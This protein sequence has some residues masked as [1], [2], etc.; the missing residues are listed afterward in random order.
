MC[1]GTIYY[2][3]SDRQGLSGVAFVATPAISK[4]VLGYNPIS[5]RI[6]SIRLQAKPLNLSVVQVYAPTSAAS[7]DDI[8]NFYNA[9]QDV[10]DGLPNKD[11]VL[12]VG[13]FN[14]KIG[15]G[16]QHDDEA[17]ILGQFGLGTRNERGDLLSEFCIG[18]NLII[19]NTMFSQHPRRLYTWQGPVKS[20]RNQIDYILIK[21]RWKSSIKVAKTLPGADIGSD[22]QLLIADVRVKLKKTNNTQTVKRFNLQNISKHYWLE[23]N[24]R[25]EEL[26]SYEEE[27][28]PE[29]LWTDIKES[30]LDS[31]NKHVPVKRR[32]KATPWLSR[33]VIDLADERRQL[34]EA[35]L[36]TSNMYRMMSKEIQQKSRRDK[37]THLNH[38]CNELEDHSAKNNSRYLFRGVKDLTRKTKAK[39]ATIKDE[40]GKVLTEENEIKDRWK[41]YCEKLYAS[42]EETSVDQADFSYDDE[43]EPDIL[44]S[45][46]KNAIRKL[47]NN[48]A[49]GI[50][51]I[52]G[53]LLKNFDN[54]GVKILLQ[55]C[56]KVWH[57]RIWP[58]DWKKSLFI[59]LPKKGDI[60]E[61]KN[62]RTIALIP[63]ASKILLH[64]LN[65]RLR[66]H[67]ER[68][69]PPEQAGF[70][71]GR[72]TRDH[73]ANIRHIIEKCKEYR[74][75]VYLCFI[76]YSKAFD[77]VRYGPLW[78]AL[79]ALGIPRHLIHLMKNLYDGQLA[80]VR[81]AFGNSEWFSL[82]QGVRQG[83]ILSPTLFNMYAEYIMRKV[84]DGWHGGISIGGWQLNNLR[85]ADDT[86]LLATSLQELSVLVSRVKRESEM[87]GLHLNVTKTKLMIIGEEDGDN[88]QL[89]VDG[90]EIE[91]VKQ[92]NFLGSLIT[93][94]GGCDKE[95]RRR[96]AMAR[97]AMTQL[98]KIWANRGI[99]KTTKVRLVQALIFPI[100]TYACET[101]TLTSAS[102]K[103]INAF[104]MWCWRR[105]L[106]ITWIMKRTNNSVLQEVNVKNR[107]LGIINSHT[108]SYFGH[109][110]RRQDVCLEKSLMQG[111]I[112]GGRRPGRPKARWIDRIKSTAGQ[113]LRR[114]YQLA[115]D[116]PLWRAIVKVTSHQP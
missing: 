41:R 24:N 30:I 112:E 25:F 47:K 52:P 114:I 115:A 64:I 17:Q 21:K 50:D 49:P 110:A 58:D 15:K 108:L 71:R 85:Y 62:N 94:E 91:K 113:P 27:R 77:C 57:T 32:K 23:T 111:K 14:A 106:R 20:I 28:T 88:D 99:T 3:G 43:E 29:E 1:L 100:A 65:E 35:G 102:C 54:A 8:N 53:E 79:E 39:L 48:K 4:F 86:T 19:S 73:I 87:M 107:L 13:D 67:I 98:S 51:D 101:W 7:E 34:K 74:R 105:M 109:V 76:D 31:A 38:L 95:I 45:E 68:E 97:S 83:C 46:V 59:T 72:G 44:L 61:C 63:H 33:E 12:V 11:V 42:Q 16:T 84:L 18:N 22:H 6:I 26:L 10:L 60:N 104:E 96:V 90:Q 116:R 82:G 55:L 80:C 2:S 78:K 89:T 66:P 5:D 103:K 93:T 36:Q 75:K 37:N 56:N 70:R 92:F 69:L 81:T 9:L 40:N